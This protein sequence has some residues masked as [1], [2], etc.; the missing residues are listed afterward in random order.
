MFT[1]LFRKERGFEGSPHP[2]YG[3][4]F[5]PFSHGEG[6]MLGLWYGAGRSGE[7]LPFGVRLVGFVCHEEAVVDAVEVGFE[8]CGAVVGGTEPLIVRRDFRGSDRPVGQVKVLENVSYGAGGE[9]RHA[10][11]EILDIDVVDGVD[12]LVLRALLTALKRRNLH[13]DSSC[14]RFA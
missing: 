2:C 12:K 14:S 5:M 9:A 11:P 13:V 6:G 1:F 4:E 10:V 3:R 7:G 8:V